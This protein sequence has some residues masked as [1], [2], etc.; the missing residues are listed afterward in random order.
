MRRF[1]AAWTRLANLWP[2]CDV[3]AVKYQSLSKSLIP[4]ASAE[5]QDLLE[6]RGPPG[7][8]ELLE[9]RDPPVRL[10]QRACKV[11]K[12]SPVQRVSKGHKAKQ[13]FK[14][15]LDQRERLAHAAL[16]EQM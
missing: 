15:M 8:R 6:R 5:R 11:L 7:H 2:P 14:V 3:G 1:G 10:A 12:A 16:M 9:P 4:L 13:V